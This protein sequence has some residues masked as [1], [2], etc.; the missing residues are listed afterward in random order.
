MGGVFNGDS[1]G[2]TYDLNTGAETSLPELMGMDEAALVQQLKSLTKS[3]MNQEP[4]LWFPEAWDTVDS[5]TLDEFEYYVNDGELILCY[6]TYTLAPGAMGCVEVPT[7]MTIAPAGQSPQGQPEQ[8]QNHQPASGAVSNV[9]MDYKYDTQEYG[10]VR[11]L[12]A[13]GET[14]WSYETDRY[15]MV[16]IQRVSEIGTIGDMYCLVEGGTVVAL[17]VQTG[18]VRWTNSDFGGGAPVFA[19]DA[20]NLY[21]SGYLGPDLCIISRSGQTV[22]LADDLSEDYMWPME[23]A[24]D[25]DQLVSTYEGSMTGY[26]G[27]YR[28]RVNPRTL[29]TSPM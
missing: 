28:L 1:Y 11:G 8:E 21:L 20:K 10:I 16:Q 23:V 13:G 22:A 14:V 2:L 3:Y 26:G 5:F 29:E 17:D 19:W 9:V 25:G 27:P 24:L 4:D 12:S 18:Q 7:G 15:D 6:A